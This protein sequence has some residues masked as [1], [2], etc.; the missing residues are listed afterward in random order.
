[1]N[2]K[3]VAAL[4]GGALFAASCSGGDSGVASVEANGSATSAVVSATEGD[5]LD[6]GPCD[7]VGSI[8]VILQC[9]TLAVPLDYD[10]PE[11]GQ[12]DIAVV[13]ALS[14]DA[15]ERIGSLVVNPGGPGGSGIEF[16]TN[17]AILFSDEITYRF[18]LV[19]FDPRGV[20]ASSAVDCPTNLDDDVSLLAEGDDAAW[21]ELVTDAT[22]LTGTCSAGSLEIA[23]HLGTNNAAR[24]LDEIRQALGDDALTYVGFSYG[25]RLGATYAELFPQ[26]VRALVLDGGV[27]PTLDQAELA[28]DQGAGFDR[29][30]DSFSATCEADKDCVLREIGPAVRIYTGLVEELSGDNTLATDDPDRQLTQGEFQLGVL[31]ALYSKDAWPILAEALY[32]AESESDGTLIHALV[33]SFVGRRPDGTYSNAQLANNFINC[34]DNPDRLPTPE[35]REEVGAAAAMSVYFDDLLRAST[36]CLGIPESSDALTIGS[37]AGSAP[38]LVVGNT[39]DPATPYEWSVALADSLES[40]VLYTAEAEGHTAYLSVPCVEETVNAYLIDLELPAA[41]SSCSDAEDS[42]YFLPAGESDAD[43]L[44]AL[45]DCLRDNGAEIPDFSLADLVADPTGGLIVEALDPSNPGFIEA[46]A[47][48]DDLLD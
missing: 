12:I 13:R 24:D 44:M 40:A 34:A 6:W 4:V 16:L 42:D 28:T 47:A 3:I 21:A 20:G 25:T 39:G 22:E 45:L 9:A 35:T 23:P 32:L 33:D 11:G 19:S 36:G 26:N 41:G 14:A 30:L 5:T 18:D 7:D 17:G 31:A 48:C 1:M 38:I 10:N 29:A 15:D 27:K 2:R 37:A 8:L 43:E 46:A